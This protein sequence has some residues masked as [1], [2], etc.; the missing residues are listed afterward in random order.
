MQVYT[1]LSYPGLKPIANGGEQRWLRS[2]GVSIYYSYQDRSN[3][4]TSCGLASMRRVTLATFQPIPA[5]CKITQKVSGRILFILLSGLHTIPPIAV[6]RRQIPQPIPRTVLGDLAYDKFFVC[7]EKTDKWIRGQIK[8]PDEVPIAHAYQW[9]RDAW[10]PLA[11]W[12]PV[13]ASEQYNH[14]QTLPHGVLLYGSG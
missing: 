13:D 9:K 5:W 1:R 12:E 11:D 10:Y 4:E 2:S 6:F 8:N 3:S 14:S 7:P